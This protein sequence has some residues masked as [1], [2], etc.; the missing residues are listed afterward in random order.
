VPP[1]WTVLVWIVIGGAAGWLTGIIVKGKGYGCIGN[2][3]VGIVGSVVGG[4]LFQIIPGVS[5]MPGLIGSLVTAV[6]GAV[7][8]IVVLRFFTGT[9]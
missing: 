5:P 4:W 2:V 9:R 1:L 8:L 6:I 7:V 3:I